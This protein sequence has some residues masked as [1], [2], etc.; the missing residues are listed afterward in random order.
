MIEVNNLTKHFGDITAVNDVSFSIKKGD[1]LGFLGPNGAGKSTTMRMITGY[2]TPESG[3][4]SICGT[5]AL[6]DPITAKEKIGYLPESA[7]LYPEMKV[8]AFLK[9]AAAMRGLTGASGKTAIARVVDLCHLSGVANQT[10]RTLSKG[11]KH[12]TCFAQALIH[13][14]EVLVLDEPTDGLDPNQKHEMRCLIKEMGKEKAIIISTH[15]LEEVDAACSRVAIIDRGSIIFDGTSGELLNRGPGA[16]VFLRVAGSNGKQVAES[17]YQISGIRNIDLIN[18]SRSSTSLRIVAKTSPD[19]VREA[20]SQHCHEVGWQILELYN[21]QH[22]LDDIFRE[23]TV[24]EVTD[25]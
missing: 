15:I 13:D 2:L 16:D 19:G 6:T 1:V 25:E 3:A 7:P 20:V 8:M 24:G 11:Y 18:K 22:R 14:P 21:R 4:I 10:I 5:D 23:L 17:L 9:F 12:R